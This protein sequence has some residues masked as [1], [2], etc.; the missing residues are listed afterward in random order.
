MPLIT[1]LEEQI[2]KLS[3]FLSSYEESESFIRQPDL[4]KEYKQWL[5]KESNMIYPLGP[6]RFR[7]Y[8]LDRNIKIVLNRSNGNKI[9]LKLKN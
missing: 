6:K 7:N 5:W 3:T 9:Y 4:Y 8:L 2:D 1:E